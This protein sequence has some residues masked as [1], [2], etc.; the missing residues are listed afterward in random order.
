MRRPSSRIFAV[1][2]ALLITA[3]GTA[4]SNSAGNFDTWYKSFVTK[5]HHDTCPQ[6][7]A[8]L[9]PLRDEKVDWDAGRRQFFIQMPDPLVVADFPI[10]PFVPGLENCN[11]LPTYPAE[12]DVKKLWDVTAPETPDLEACRKAAFSYLASYNSLRAKRHPVA[13]K[14]LCSGR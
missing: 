10:G 9:D 7:I 13:A 2:I 1:A 4:S 14:Q 5:R 12:R 11:V 8:R 3:C 6:E